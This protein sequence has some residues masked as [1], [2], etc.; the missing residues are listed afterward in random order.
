MTVFKYFI[1][2][3]SN[4]LNIIY[5]LIIKINIIFIDETSFINTFNY[6]L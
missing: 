2:S 4:F 3:F 6:L 5:S 1:I